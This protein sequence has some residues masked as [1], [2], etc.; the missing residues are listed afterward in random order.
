MNGP[1]GFHRNLGVIVTVTAPTD[2]AIAVPMPPAHPLEPLTAAELTAASGVLV[3]ERGL[4]SQFRFVSIELREP[5]KA[6]VLAWSPGD[7]PLDRQ[8]FVVLYERGVR[9]THEAVVSLTSRTV[10][11]FRTVPGVTPPMMLEEFLACEDVVRAD[12]RWQAAMRRRGVT[13]FSMAMVDPWP[14]GYTGPPDDPAN[15]RIAR[16]LTFLRT[17]ADENGYARPV[18]DLIA[19]VDLDAMTVLGVEDHAT[20]ETLVP[21]PTAGGNYIPEHFLTDPTN[22][23]AFDRLRDD[24]KTID[25]T[26]PDGPS[27]TVDGHHVRWQKWSMR[28]GFTPRE[29]LVLHQVGYDD[30]GTV[31]PVVYRASMSEMFIP[32]ADPAPVHRL[33]NVFDMGEVGIGLLANPLDLGCDCLGEIFYFDGVVNDQ[34]GQPVTIPNAICLHEEDVGIAWK[35]TDFRSG[36]VEVRRMRRLVVSMICTVG[37]YEYGFFWYFYLDG[38]IEFEAKLTGIISSGAVPPGGEPGY[39]VMVAPQV[40]GPHHQHFFSVRLDLSIDG[41]ANSVVEVDSVPIERG[42]ANPTGT[43]WKT[44]ETTLASEASAARDVDAAKARYWK[45]VNP[46]SRNGLGGPVGYKLMPGHT[47]PVLA[48][49]DSAFA[50]RGRFAAHQ[51]WVTA[52]DP[53]ERYAAGA[54]PYQS[55][56]D[57]GLPAWTAADRPLEGTDVVVWYTAGAHHIVRPED[58]PVMPVTR[59]GFELKPVGFFD[60]NPAL[61]LPRSTPHGACHHHG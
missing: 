24:L 6:A 17:A 20:D 49:P 34:D 25:I 52:Y 12:P 10:P 14:P 31:R 4:G 36:Q 23:P 11:E 51:L 41:P 19:V 40:Y 18:E 50:A 3:A 29:G 37:N 33:K 39:G 48:Q 26:Q 9:A 45:V 46:E 7:E 13:D 22:T 15:G 44:V 56:G 27:F 55:A 43:A 47:A 53:D 59:V 16:P 28:L 42:P 32:Y 57:E 58:W 38:T 30:R 61:D 8:A 60:G 1:A 2:P 21:I 5:P 35:H 54:Y